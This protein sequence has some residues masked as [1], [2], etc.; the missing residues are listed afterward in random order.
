MFINKNICTNI[1]EIMGQD[2]IVSVIAQAV[3]KDKFLTKGERELQGAKILKRKLLGICGWKSTK[4]LEE[5]AQVLHS[6][7]IASSLEEGRGIVPL[8]VGRE[9][10]YGGGDLKFKEVEDVEGNKRYRISKKL[11]SPD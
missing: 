11:Y 6:T 1:M 5:I 9:I 8:L 4:T 3:R 10:S 2:E 7:G